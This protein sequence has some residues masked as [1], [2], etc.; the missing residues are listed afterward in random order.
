M[1]RTELKDRISDAECRE[2]TGLAGY[3]KSQC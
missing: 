3:G 1:A 2:Q